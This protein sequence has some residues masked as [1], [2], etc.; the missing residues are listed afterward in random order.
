MQAIAIGSEYRFTPSG[1]TE[2]KD[3]KS[4]GMTLLGRVVY[5]HPQRRYFTV[6][7]VLHGIAIRESFHFV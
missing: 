3:S 1:F 6:E 7:A 5:I 4:R 2:E